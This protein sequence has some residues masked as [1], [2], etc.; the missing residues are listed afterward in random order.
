MNELPLPTTP[1]EFIAIVERRKTYWQDRVD[2]AVPGK[3]TRKRLVNLTSE[4]LN[5]LDRLDVQAIS[6]AEDRAFLRASKE[7]HYAE[8]L[9]LQGTLEEAFKEAWEAQ[10]RGRAV[11]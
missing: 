6:T 9:P 8:N 2:A 4:L 5:L 3:T 7:N 11:A 10:E 1:E